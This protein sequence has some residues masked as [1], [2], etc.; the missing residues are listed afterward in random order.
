M[1]CTL[2]SIWFLKKNPPQNIWKK[3]LL[4]NAFTLVIV[5][6]LLID[7]ISQNTLDFNQISKRLSFVLIPVVFSVASKQ[8]QNLALKTYVFFLTLLSSVLLIAGLVRSVINKD[9]II[10]GNWDSETTE[11]FYQNEMFINWGELSYKRLFFFFDMHPSYYALFSIIAIIIL[12][13]T[14]TIKL[15]KLLKWSFILIH[16][17]MIIF[18]SSKTGIISL[19]IVLLAYLFIGQSNKNR[20]I[21]ASVVLLLALIIVKTPSTEIRLKS[22]YKSLKSDG[23]LLNMSST[24][25][26]LALWNSLADLSLKELVVGVGNTGGRD[27]I[28][29]NTGI[30]KNMHNQFL[31]SL[32]NAGFIGFSLITIFVFLPL[33]FKRNIFTISLVLIV[34]VNLLFENMLDRIW[35][36]TAI[37]FFYAFIIFG[38][39]EM[40]NFKSA[41]N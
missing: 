27:R 11:R 29:T 33:F 36:I 8:T 28:V 31:Q 32:L 2:I 18:L 17:I 24:S 20:L 10:Y 23:N 37:S 34:F 40:L 38:S 26:R 9:Q 5:I 13:F 7:L 19:F 1:L 39:A 22:A 35:G 12:I 6:G 4:F 30:D 15:K 25:E 21:G 14:Q 3:Y 16:M 41:K